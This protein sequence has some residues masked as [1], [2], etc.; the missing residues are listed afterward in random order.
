MTDNH[1][2]DEL[3]LRAFKVLETDKKVSAIMLMLKQLNAITMTDEMRSATIA[4]NTI[5][6]VG[7]MAK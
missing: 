7:E 1:E 4:H 5:K 2:H 6:Q 3:M